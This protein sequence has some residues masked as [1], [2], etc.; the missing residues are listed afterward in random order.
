MRQH[1]RYEPLA[2]AEPRACARV[3]SFGR[4]GRIVNF[5]RGEAM[6][7]DF[8]DGYLRR[9]GYGFSVRS[10][11]TAFTAVGV[12]E[13][14]ELPE[15]S[16]AETVLLEVDGRSWMALIP[17]GWEVEFEG[18]REELEAARVRPLGE[19][20]EDATFVGT[21]PGAEPGFGGLYSLPV[22]MDEALL[23]NEALVLR[24]GVLDTSVEVPLAE[25]LEREQPNTGRI[26]VRVG[27][28][29]A[30]RLGETAGPGIDE[31]LGSSGAT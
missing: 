31:S 5:E 4:T 23:Q 17:A 19:Q 3:L 26:A 6:I 12:A 24:A 25:F 16:V 8:V 15:E 13:Q 20:Q 10:H 11:G 14:L 7:P 9:R 28:G 30:S 2:G 22:I 21:V 1:P 27:A 18:V 29:M